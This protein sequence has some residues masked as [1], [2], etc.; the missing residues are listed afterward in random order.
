LFAPVSAIAE[1]IRARKLSPVELTQAYLA[2]ID[3]HAERLRCFVTVTRERAMSD[4]RR[5]EQEIAAGQ[6]KGVLHGVPY[7]LKDLVDTQGIRTTWG[8]ALFAERVPARDATVAAKLRAAGAVL[9]GKLSM[10]ELAGSLGYKRA[11]AALNGA[12]RTPWDDTR[13][14]GGSSSGSGAAV[15]AGLV[16]F[17]I[18]SET[19]GSI[20]CPSAFCGI[21]GLRPTYGVVSRHGAMALAYTM[22]K[23]GPIARTATDCALVLAQIA[24]RD[25]LDPSSIDAPPGLD[26]VGPERA[27]GLRVGV[28]DFAGKPDPAF[29]PLFASAIEVLRAAG[30]TVK[31]AT[32]PDLPYDEVG[33]TLLESEGLAAMEDV[34]VR[35]NKWRTLADPS[36]WEKRAKGEAP[37]I[38]GADYV[39]ATRLRTTIQ[40]EI[41]RFFARYDAIV[42]PSFPIAPPPIEADFDAWFADLGDKDPLG[43]LGGVAGLPAVATPI[44]FFTPKDAS[45]V[46]PAS[47]VLVTRPHGEAAILSLAAAYQARTKHHE[48]RPAL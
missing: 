38:S 19:W 45:R 2:R 32:L 40:N 33:V 25:P 44:G 48:Q 18:G 43:A 26:T 11:H 17:A 31:A 8:A 29:R 47:M 23:L 10:I 4:A 14:A 16:A 7:G 41:D 39:K 46:V 20:V 3:K 5:A 30:A 6:Y 27:K 1:R 13:W 12:C 36:A 28:L 35:D 15:A 21:T 24:G 37:K 34:V 9:L 42:A 22:D